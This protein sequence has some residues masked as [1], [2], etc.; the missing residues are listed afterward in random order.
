MTVQLKK[1]LILWLFYFIPIISFAE[2]SIKSV[3]VSGRGVVS[4]PQTIA[5]IMLS[6]SENAET[7]KEAQDKT[8]VK[9]AKLILVLD[10][11]KILSK[12]TT[13]ITINP[14]W[15]YVNNK[16][17][18]TGYNASYTIKIK[19]E[20]PEAGQIIDLAVNLGASVV[21]ELQFSASD[22]AVFKAQLEAIKLATI[23]ARKYADASLNSLNLKSTRVGQINIQVSN[24]RPAPVNF[25]FKTNSSADGGNVPSTT[26]IPGEE[27]VS[28]DVIISMNY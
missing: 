20:I 23:N 19:S 1:Y 5:T 10:S 6:V 26:I 17:T 4:I 11:A 8:R 24:D 28:A 22:T 3:T 2:N 25:A 13:V 7:S 14:T 18:I 21:N 27:Q 9:F 12:E 16:S 15:S